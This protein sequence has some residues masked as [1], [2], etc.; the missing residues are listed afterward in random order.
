MIKVKSNNEQKHLAEIYDSPQPNMLVNADFKS[1]VISQRHENIVGGGSFPSEG[2]SCVID[3]WIINTLTLTAYDGYIEVR[4]VDSTGH[5]ILQNTGDKFI[6]SSHSWYVNVK[7]CSDGCYLWTSI[8]DDNKWHS[9]GNLSVGENIFKYGGS[10]NPFMGFGISIPSGGFIKLYQCKLEPGDSFT[11]MPHWDYHEQL[12]VCKR[13][14]K[15][16]NR[17]FSGYGIGDYVYLEYDAFLERE[18]DPTIQ[19]EGTEYLHLF[20]DGEDNSYDIST[21]EIIGD[22]RGYI[23]INGFPNWSYYTFSGYFDCD[24]FADYESY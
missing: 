5:S 24:V 23:R 3:R 8:S 22:S 18:D 4:N 12:D 10:S 1:G 15:K 13:T 14:L 16:M 21:R 19:L 6:Q 7:D 2:A 11:G 20:F 9:I 17:N